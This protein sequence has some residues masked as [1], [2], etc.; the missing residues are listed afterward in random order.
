MRVVLPGDREGIYYM[1]LEGID[2]PMQQAYIPRPKDT[3]IGK[4]IAEKKNVAYIVDISSFYAMTVLIKGLDTRLK[5]EDIIIGNVGDNLEN[6][7]NIRVLKGGVLIELP[8]SKIPR[9]IGT[10]GEMLKHISNITGSKLEIGKNG[11]VWMNG[12]KLHTT[13]KILETIVR[14]AHIRG[15]TDY[16]SKE[17]G[18]R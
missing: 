18:E 6:L 10:R 7:E 3:V 8:P 11:L 4:V 13:I 1:Y 12:G 16:I 17:F 14:R 15:L 2:V 9:V 5:Q